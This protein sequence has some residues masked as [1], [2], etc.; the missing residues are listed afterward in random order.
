MTDETTSVKVSSPWDEAPPREGISNDGRFIR[1]VHGIIRDLLPP[2]AEI[3]WADF[4]ITISIAYTALAFFLTAANGSIVQVVSW[5]IAGLA[6]YR[7]SVFTHELVHLRRGTFIPFR[8]TWNVLFGIPCLM[9][10]FLYYDHVSHHV[11]HS[12]GTAD[13]AEY[14]PLAHGPAAVVY[15]YLA[16]IVVIPVA[17]VI[18]VL[19]LVPLSFLIPPLRR[20][21]WER[22]SSLAVINPQYRRPLPGREERLAANLQEIACVLFV[23]GVIAAIVWGPLSWTLLPKLYAVFLVVVSV[24]YLRAL[25]SHCYRNEGSSMSY[26]EQLLDS[27]TIPGHPLWTELWA[28]LGMRYHALHHLVPSL[29]YHAMGRAHRRLIRQLPPDS[30]YHATLRRS[31]LS[32]ILQVYHEARA[33]SGV[34]ARVGKTTPSG[35]VVS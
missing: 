34:N 17:A 29:P 9:P 25:G 2:K 31:L 1:E 32:A 26:V 10:S 19:L 23:Y 15:A 33:G 22:A 6:L 18:R 35:N 12:Y 7:A 11:R 4:L 20:V 8:I 28:P 3:Y 21:L 27:T 30:P 14:Y 13:D 5:L 16:Q 24:N